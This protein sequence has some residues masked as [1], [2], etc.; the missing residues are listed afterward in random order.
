MRNWSDRKTSTLSTVGTAE[1][2]THTREY[3]LNNDEKTLARFAATYELK[4]CK[5]EMVLS[6]N[7]VINGTNGDRHWV[8]PNSPIQVRKGNHSKMTTKGV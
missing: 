8:Y 3:Q 5:T 2:A 7:R 4:L 1:R 6:E